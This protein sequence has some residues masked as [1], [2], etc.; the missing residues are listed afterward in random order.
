MAAF[1]GCEKAVD[2]DVPFESPKLVLNGFMNPDSSFSAHISKSQFVLD[3]ADLKNIPDATVRI[4]EGENLLGE[5]EHQ[6]EGLYKLPDIFPEPGKTYTIQAEKAG[7][8]EVNAKEIVLNPLNISDF[9]YDTTGVKEIGEIKVAYEFTLHDPA[10]EKNY[11]LLRLTEKGLRKTYYGLNSETEEPEW[12]W[13]P[14][15]HL[16]STES[17]DLLMES[18]CVGFSGCGFFLRDDF[19]DGKDY[20][21]KLTSRYY[22]NQHDRDNFKDVSYYFAIYQISETYYRYLKTLDQNQGIQDNPFAEPAKVYSNIEGG[23]GIWTSLTLTTI[24]IGE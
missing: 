17:A 6:E 8:A 15:V 4:Y 16:L 10:G 21:I 2:V 20:R 7:F 1:T 22:K 14:Y 11:Y 13:L 18:Y 9:K 23:Y 3:R 12:K 19:L 24:Q 5:M